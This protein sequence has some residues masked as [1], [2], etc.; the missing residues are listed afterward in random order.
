MK[1]LLA[2]SLFEII[3]LAEKDVSWNLFQTQNDEKPIAQTV[4]IHEISHNQ[5]EISI[6]A[7]E[8]FCVSGSAKYISYILN[9]KLFEVCAEVLFKNGVIHLHSSFVFYNDQAILF[10]GPS[11]IGKTTQAELWRDHLGA[12]IANGDVTLIRNVGGVWTAFGAPIHGS[13]PY[14][15]NMQAPI[16]AVV[17]LS[18]SEE[19]HLE[20]MNGYEALCFCMKEIYRPEM[21]EETQEILMD[22]MDGFFSEIPVYH[23]S[24]RPDKDSVM[25]VKNELNM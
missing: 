9:E 5:F 11:G 23:M 1:C 10:I 18:Q 25:L 6:S 22:T 16:V 19:N 20:R 3:G 8:K 14:C 2:D 21:A 15:E 7:N 12:T 24:C 4:T 13:S 17:A